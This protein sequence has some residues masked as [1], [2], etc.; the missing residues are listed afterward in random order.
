MGNKRSNSFR[1]RCHGKHHGETEQPE[2]KLLDTP[3]DMD[4]TYIK[5]YNYDSSSSSSST[6]EPDHQLQ[7][8]R[9][10]LSDRSR[11]SSHRRGR[12]KPEQ[13]ELPEIT[14]EIWIGKDNDGDSQASDSDDSDYI[15]I[16]DDEDSENDEESYSGLPSPQEISNELSQLVFGSQGNPCRQFRRSALHS[17]YRISGWVETRDA[18][19]LNYFLSQEGVTKLL[20]FILEVLWEEEECNENRGEEFGYRIAVECIRLA[21]SVVSGVCCNEERHGNSQKYSSKSVSLR[22]LAGVTTTLVVN[23]SG[24][25]TLLMAS[26][27]CCRC[28]DKDELTYNAVE[29]SERVWDAIANTCATAS[30]DTAT[31]ITEK[32]SVPIWDTGFEV[33]R[34]FAVDTSSTACPKRMAATFLLRANVFRTFNRISFTSG[35]VSYRG[36]VLEERKVFKQKKI[37]SR[38]LEILSNKTRYGHGE[39]DATVNTGISSISMSLDSLGDIG[40]IE[41]GDYLEEVLSFFSECQ[42]QDLLFRNTA[43]NSIPSSPP[44]S[45]PRSPRLTAPPSPTQSTT[46]S[47]VTATTASETTI[48]SMGGTIESCNTHDAADERWQ[49]LCDGLVPLC[50]LGLQKFGVDNPKI[51]RSAIGILDAAL[52]SNDANQRQVLLTE[53]ADGTF[54]ALA[55]CLASETIDEAEKDEMKEVVRKVAVLIYSA[56][57]G[58]SGPGSLLNL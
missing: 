44:R 20:D 45:P 12:M 21:A 6:E 30:D 29:A 18:T 55:P 1:K 3:S 23:H 7:N 46:P 14:E 33:M 54:E 57:I 35:L 39:D 22:F 42:T 38:A 43:T 11:S 26:D 56:Y 10:D 4:E 27:L 52:N 50:V 5:S 40:T 28:K 24:I 53:V 25:E 13:V 32:L 16:I 17:L 36:K 49:L 2:T 51:R 37:L 58:S 41:E 48:A 19:F 34:N 15:D 9:S 8:S 47:A 31:L